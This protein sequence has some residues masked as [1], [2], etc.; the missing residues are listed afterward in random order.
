M[1]RFLLFYLVCLSSLLFC[2]WSGSFESLKFQWIFVDCNYISRR[3]VLNWVFRNYMT[4]INSSISAQD[5]WRIHV[6]TIF[7]IHVIILL[8][9][10]T[11]S[12]DCRSHNGGTPGLPVHILVTHLYDPDASIISSISSSRQLQLASTAYPNGNLLTIT[13]PRKSSAIKV[14]VTHATTTDSHKSWLHSR[15]YPNAKIS[16][17]SW[18]LSQKQRNLSTFNRGT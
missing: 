1:N 11:Q 12:V 17:S 5:T 3:Q 18:D 2:L 7:F 4:V 6:F 9:F 8:N 16:A 14:P 15:Y 10:F 13:S